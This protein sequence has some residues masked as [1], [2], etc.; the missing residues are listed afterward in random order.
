MRH[1]GEE[2]EEEKN[3]NSV[4][5]QSWRAGGKEMSKK[6]DGSRSNSQNVNK[7]YIVSVER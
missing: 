7:A 4:S 3:G 1:Q 6:V 5:R 2:E